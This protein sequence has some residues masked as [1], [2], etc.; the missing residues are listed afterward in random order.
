MF[1]ETTEEVAAIVRNCAQHAVP[2]IPFG[3]GTSVEG[4]IAAPQGG[5]CIDLSRMDA[6]LE[7]WAEDMV[8]SVQA[9]VTRKQ[10]NSSLRNTGLFFPIDPGADASIGG[11]TSTR[12]SGTNAVRYGTMKDNVLGLTVVLPDGS[13]THTGGRAKKS[14]AGYDLTRLF[15]GAEGTLGIITEVTLRLHGIPEEVGAA[16]CS[17]PTMKDAVDCVIAIIQLG[18]PIARIELIDEVQIEASN[19]FSKLS[20]KPAPTLFMEFHGSLASVKDQI[21]QVTAIAEDFGAHEFDWASDPERRN[22][23]WQARHDAYYAILALKPGGRAWS[24]D[25]CVPI[26]KLVDCILAAQESIIAHRLTASIVG[27]VGDGNFHAIICLDPDDK[28]EW[29]RATLFNKEL[30]EKAI[31]VGGTCTGEHGVGI[32]KINYLA[33]EQADALPVMRTIKSALD[34]KNIMNPGKVLAVSGSPI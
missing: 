9:G 24:T 23:L 14:S 34:P 19:R 2:V 11:M 3:T 13:I 25:T 20:L 32:G 6:V 28:S 1:A 10:L 21:E 4:G 31:S 27:H 16:L 33:R 7:V 5:V 15:C 29:A 12:A 8:V 30:V 22:Q 18:V 17:F 26:S